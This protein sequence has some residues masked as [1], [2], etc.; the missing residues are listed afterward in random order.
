MKNLPPKLAL[1]V[2]CYNE[3]E[4]LKY[5]FDKLIT[6]IKYLIDT[7]KISKD[8]FIVFIDDGS[9]DKSWKIIL[10]ESKTNNFILGLKLSKNEG[11]QSALIAGMEYVKNKCDC[12]VSIDADLQQD[13]NAIERF[14]KKYLEGSEI[15]L[16]IRNSRESDSYFKRHSAL[17]FYNLMQLMG[18]DIVKNHADYRLLSNRAN[19]AILEYKEINLFLRGLIPLVGFKTEYIYFD[20]KKRFAGKSKYTL[21]KML[22][23]SI[24]GIT[25]FS[26]IPLRI[27]SLVGFLVFMLSFLMGM[28]IFIISIFTEQ[29]LPGWAS[30]VLPIYFLGGIQIFSVG[31]LGEY[32]GRIYRE[33]KRRPRY[34]IEE[35]VK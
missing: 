29:A 33:V 16:G 17:L 34:F 14:V 5:T 20:V 24:D 15:V 32:I 8:S 12:L 30:V 9:K 2:P 35:E 13:E 7:Q 10:D 28:Y 4:V 21:F 11:H 6:V 31:I 25:S 1:V 22:S 18:V 26:I 19:C 3:E 27:V 23:F